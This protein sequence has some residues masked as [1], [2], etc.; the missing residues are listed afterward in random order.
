[1]SPGRRRNIVLG[2]RASALALRQTGLVAASLRAA[3]SGLRLDTQTVH[4][5]GDRDQ[6]TPLDLLG[7]QGVFVKEIENALL[8]GEIDLAVHSLKDMPAEQPRGLTIGAVLAREDPREALVSRLGLGLEELPQGARVGTGSLR[9]EAQLRAY[10]PDLVMLGLRGN[11]DTRL[12]KAMTTE[13]DA[14]VL[15]L[16]GLLRLGRAAE[17][18]AIIPPEVI[19]PAVG[20]GAIAVEVRAGDLEARALV[21]PLDDPSTR[22]ATE[23]ER[24][25]LRALGGG[26]HVPIAGHALVRGD[27]LWLRG[28]VA[29]PSGERILRGSVLGPPGAAEELGRELAAKLLAQGC[30]E[31]LAEEADRA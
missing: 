15:A 11:V 23:A 30:G 25:L 4:T 28:L 10:R 21:A 16:A 7:G 14:I 2:T 18:T 5:G 3:H 8:A 24:S 6:E 27:G 1:M 26:C 20:Q 22:A 9:R 17:V 31:I 12:K 29:S 19:L 13:Y